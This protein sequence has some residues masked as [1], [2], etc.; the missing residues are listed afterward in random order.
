[1]LAPF[2]RGAPGAKSDKV[3]CHLSALG[4]QSNVFLVSKVFLLYLRALHVEGILTISHSLKQVKGL[5][6]TSSP[7]P[8]KKKKPH[9][10]RQQKG[11][12]KRERGAGGRR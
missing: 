7:Q 10:Y 2:C 8:E 12:H 1:M 4:L 3:T 5:S 11:D 9:I 6:N